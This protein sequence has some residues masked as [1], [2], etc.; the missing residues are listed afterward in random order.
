[1]QP[2]Q[3]AQLVLLT[4]A[5]SLGIFAN[6]LDT[7]IAN[8]AI[9]TIAGNMGVS[10]DQGTWVIT[11]FTVTLAI[12]LP[13]TGWLSKRFGEVKLFSIS[14]F[15]FTI[16]SV[17]CAMSTTLP[18]LVFFRVIQ[19]AVAGPMIPLSQS[20]LLANYPH[21]K[22][23]LATA[24]WA[25]V[26]VAAP[27]VGP[28]LGGWLTDNYSWPWIFYI[29]VPVGLF[30]AFVTWSLLKERETDIVRTPVDIIG[31]ILLAVGVG[32]LQVLL[33][34]GNDD[35]WFNS[36]FINSLAC[37][38]IISLTFFVAWELTE[39][40]PIVD[41][42]LFKRRNFAVG[43]IGISLGYMAYFGSVV[44][45]PLWLQTQM[46]YTPTWA[47]VATAPVGI[48]PLFFSPVIGMIMGRMD[49][50]VIVSTGFF[51]F[52]YASFWAAGFDTDVSFQNIAISRLVLG[53]ALPCFFIPLISISL[54]GLHAKQV[55]SAAGLSNF[56]RIL[57]GSF[58]TSIFVTLWDHRERAHQSKLVESL[59][60]YNPIFNDGIDQLQQIGFG[61]A[62][63]YAQMQR[64]V[65]NQAYMLSTNDVFWISGMLFVILMLF[66]WYARPPFFSK[67][68]VAMD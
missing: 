15:L 13:L 68:D 56:C 61:N 43:T 44:I 18:M 29:N 4:V 34:K 65:V 41:L 62:E 22:K 24:L 47:G 54:S 23:G 50:R 2:I 19:G 16:A 3:G 31:L 32:C 45:L 42:A 58:G 26:A 1:M 63:S 33:D 28:I 55:A 20:I 67:P 14:T 8:V 48:I 10:A 21:E 6:V 7:S 53:A 27:V 25:T 66:V 52:A 46:G 9:P 5:V 30:S 49:L 59:T 11:S 40:N 64:S 12:A 51:I 57:A 37:V 35:D 39:K 36:V 17:L 60:H 38:S